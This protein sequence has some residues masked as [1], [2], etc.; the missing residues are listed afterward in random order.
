MSAQILIPAAKWCAIIT[1]LASLPSRGRVRALSRRS[2]GDPPRG[3]HSDLHAVRSREPNGS[4]SHDTPRTEGTRKLVARF[5]DRLLFVRYRYDKKLKRR[6]TTVELI[7]EEA[8]WTPP[9]LRLV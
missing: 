8:D 4:Q 7:V 1:A 2:S 5:G 6:F 3:S 9:P